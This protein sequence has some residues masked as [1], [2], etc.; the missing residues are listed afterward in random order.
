MDKAK[1]HTEAAKLRITK[2]HSVIVDAF[3]D[4]R[5][6][7]FRRA[8]LSRLLYVATNPRSEKRAD[9]LAAILIKALAKAGRIVRH[10]HLHWAIPAL[11]RTLLSGRKMAVQE[12]PVHLPIHSKTPEKWVAVDLETGD[13]WAGSL[14]GWKRAGTEPRHDA[15]AILRR[16][17]SGWKR[18]GAEPRHEALEI[19]KPIN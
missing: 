19:L 14:S 11:E 7:P 5:V 10:G 13:V 9:E 18:A 16:T 12:R 3:L 17:L 2:H 1:S 4:K 6:T 8:D 15:L